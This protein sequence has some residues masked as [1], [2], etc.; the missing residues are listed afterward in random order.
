MGDPGVIAVLSTTSTEVPPAA[1]RFQSIRSGTKAGRVVH[2]EPLLSVARRATV[3]GGLPG[4]S[5]QH[6]RRDPGGGRV[7]AESQAGQSADQVDTPDLFYLPGYECARQA[8]CR[9]E[10][11]HGSVGPELDLR[12]GA[13]GFEPG[14]FGDSAPP[15][16]TVSGAPRRGRALFG[17]SVVGCTHR[18]SP[19]RGERRCRSIRPGPAGG[20]AHP[21]LR[22]RPR[23]WPG[24]APVRSGADRRF[25]P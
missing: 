2:G 7:G 12:V 19:R 10:E 23:R 6:R 20:G 9:L 11:R 4:A 22:R 8:R 16:T 18:R 13:A 17:F 21:R 14:K 24:G 15:A 5:H 1:P 25:L 3:A